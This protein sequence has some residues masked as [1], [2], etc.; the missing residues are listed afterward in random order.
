MQFQKIG[1]DYIE[2]D[3][4]IIQFWGDLELLANYLLYHSW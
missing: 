2:I 3:I 4:K 1:L